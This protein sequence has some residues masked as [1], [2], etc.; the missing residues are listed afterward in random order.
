MG[1]GQALEAGVLSQPVGCRLLTY[2]RQTGVNGFWWMGIL[3]VVVGLLFIDM[4]NRRV[5]CVGRWADPPQPSQKGGHTLQ[6]HGTATHKTKIKHA[7]ERQ[8]V[9]GPQLLKLG[10]D[11][12]RHAGGALG[13]E[14]VHH[15][16]VHL[17]LSVAVGVVVLLG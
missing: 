13:E 10:H 2:T 11:A 6:K 4:S 8:R 3:V 15:G 5:L 7:P 9:L 14:A 16:L 12:V 17:Q 1:A